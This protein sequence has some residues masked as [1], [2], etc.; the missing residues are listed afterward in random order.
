MKEAASGVVRYRGRKMSR[1]MALLLKASTHHHK[2]RKY[3]PRGIDPA[4]I[5]P[6]MADV[7]RL[8]PDILSPKAR[9][10][11]DRVI[12]KVERLE[13][14]LQGTAVQAEP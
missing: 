10:L 5:S 7:Q 1:E 3:A 13:R 8:G 11:H 2:A 4:F 9:A 14:L 12:A 6:C